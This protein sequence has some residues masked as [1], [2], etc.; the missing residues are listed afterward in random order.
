MTTVQM[1]VYL[2]RRGR[3]T[4]DQVA[5][6]YREQVAAETAPVPE[7]DVKEKEEDAG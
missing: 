2:I 3:I 6:Q 4:I 1:L 7:S 5:P